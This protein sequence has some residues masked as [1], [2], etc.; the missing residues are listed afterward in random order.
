MTICVITLCLEYF[1]LGEDSV[2]IEVSLIEMDIIDSGPCRDLGG[3][4]CQLKR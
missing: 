2:L 1:L 3:D 4:F